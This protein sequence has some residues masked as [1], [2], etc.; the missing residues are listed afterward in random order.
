[1]GRL[2]LNR[3]NWDGGREN[4][5]EISREFDRRYLYAG[6]RNSRTCPKS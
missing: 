4:L 5:V 3:S 6:T 2:L 1:V